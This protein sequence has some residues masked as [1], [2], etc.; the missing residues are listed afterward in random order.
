[1][2]CEYRLGNGEMKRRPLFPP[3]NRC[4]AIALEACQGGRQ[5]LNWVNTQQDTGQLL[6]ELRGRT[7][8]GRASPG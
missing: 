1:M 3:M 6:S 8:H 2:M 7:G 5:A 4:Q